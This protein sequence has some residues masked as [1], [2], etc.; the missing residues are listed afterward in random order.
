VTDNEI[1]IAVAEACGYETM[2]ASPDLMWNKKENR[3]VIKPGTKV[4]AARLR[5]KMEYVIGKQTLPDYPNDLNAMHEAVMAQPPQMRLT[6]NQQLMES[7]RPNEAYIMDRTINAT[8]RQ[9][10]EAFLRV[11]GKW[12]ETT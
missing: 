4:E 10:A 7:L 12:K 5:M 8:A 11:L 6:I 1:R 9:R 2:M 3:A